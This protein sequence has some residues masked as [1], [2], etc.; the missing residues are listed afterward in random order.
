VA[1]R[2]HRQSRESV[3]PLRR[4]GSSWRPGR[5][6]AGGPGAALAAARL[7][8]ARLRAERRRRRR[9]LLAWG[10]RSLL[11]A[12]GLSWL[13]GAVFLATLGDGSLSL[14]FVRTAACFL[15]GTAAFAGAAELTVKQYAEA[16][17]VEAQVEAAP[18]GKRALR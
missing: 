1:E 7:R 11:A 2:F 14:W 12:G 10:R 9:Q 18:P 15:A 3:R 4:R 8:D 17:H 13:L 6:P 16:A 5:A